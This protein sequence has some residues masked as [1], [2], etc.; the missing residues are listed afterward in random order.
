MWFAV[1]YA[2]GKF[3]A[4][5]GPF[6]TDQQVMYSTDGINWTSTDAVAPKQLVYSNLRQTVSSLQ[7]HKTETNR[8]MY[9]TDGGLDWTAASAAPAAFLAISSLRRRAKFVAVGG[10]GAVMY[11]YDGISWSD[12]AQQL[13]LIIGSSVTYGDGKFVAVASTGTNQVMYSD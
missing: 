13:K 11:S 2:A 10:S 7:F 12:S 5:G 6:V 1:A 4:V 9:S 8:V 3:V